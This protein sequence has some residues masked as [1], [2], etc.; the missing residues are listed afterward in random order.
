MKP[1]HHVMPLKPL[2]FF[3]HEKGTLLAF[4]LKTYGSTHTKIKKF[5]FAEQI[6]LNEEV[7]KDLNVTVQEG[8]IVVIKR[9]NYGQSLTSFKV[10]YEDEVLVVVDKPAGLLTVADESRRDNLF[11]QMKFV[12]KNNLFICHRLDREVS[13]VLLFCKTKDAQIYIEDHWS[14]FEKIYYA[15]V[16][17]ALKQE[18]A[19]L[20]HYIVYSGQH[21]VFVQQQQK[22]GVKIIT[23]YKVIA[24]NSTYSDLEVKLHTGKKNQIRA[25]LGFIGHPI[26]G[27]IKFGAMKK[28]GNRIA[29]HSQQLVFF[30]PTTHEKIVVTSNAPF[31][32]K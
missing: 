24:S 21:K 3:C 11:K 28:W 4:L 32:A 22:N 14:E 15:R 16:E 2:K 7:V 31:L 9:E 26:L 18:H 1:Q 8:D 10:L 6:W 13:G 29:L 12:Y 20:E 17:G 25:Q 5:L 19:I 23:E 27:D 30:H